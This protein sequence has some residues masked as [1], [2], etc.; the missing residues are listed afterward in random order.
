MGAVSRGLRLC[1]SCRS[2]LTA[3]L[4]SLPALYQAC[5]QALEVRCQ[6][7]VRVVRRRRPTGIWLDELALA[8]RSDTTHLL[9]SWSE[10]IV[11]ERGVTGPTSLD[12]TALTSFVQAH[13]DWLAAHPAAADFADEIEGLAADVGRVLNPVPVR[14]TELGPCTRDGCGRMVRARAVNQSSVPQ[15]RCDAGHAWQPHQWLHLRH[16]LDPSGRRTAREVYA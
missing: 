2:L 16:R 14:I 6:H 9:S 4:A 13:L 12:V 7:S 5:E 11:D 8:V 15:V 1:N 3:R 10:M